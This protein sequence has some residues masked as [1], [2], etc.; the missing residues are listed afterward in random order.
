MSRYPDQL[1]V[2]K[3]FEAQRSLYSLAR[4]VADI[5]KECRSAAYSISEI[6]FG[7]WDSDDE[8]V[9]I[10]YSSRFQDNDSF[11]FPNCYLRMTDEEIT[12]LENERITAERKKQEAELAAKKL[13]ATEE[14]K[15]RELA[16][17][18]RLHEKYGESIGDV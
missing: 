2:D 9:V 18:K 5:V 6:E 8:I 16:T 13:K 11:T 1:S 14:A 7:S 10:T 4:E 17:Y 3:A 12:V 15:V